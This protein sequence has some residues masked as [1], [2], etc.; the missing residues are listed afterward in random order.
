MGAAIPEVR[1]DRDEDVVHER[2]AGFVRGCVGYFEANAV[3][4]ERFAFGGAS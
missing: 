1:A 3:R 2:T 4:S